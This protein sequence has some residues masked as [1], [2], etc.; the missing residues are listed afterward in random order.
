M[1]SISLYQGED[2]TIVVNTNEDLTTATEI[3]FRID[4]SPQVVKTLTGGGISG[5]T[6]TGYAIAL[7][8][9]DTTNIDAGEYKIQSRYTDSGGNINHGKFVPNKLKLIES[10]FVNPN[11]GNDYG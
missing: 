1:A 8:P 10:I 7:E 6:A 11:S 4:C 9:G 5:V 2:K 3:E